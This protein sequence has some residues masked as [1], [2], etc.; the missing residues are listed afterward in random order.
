MRARL[1][2]LVLSIL[3]SA[4]LWSADVTP[5]VSEPGYAVTGRVDWSTATLQVEISHD[6][7]PSTASL[8][9]AKGDA[10]TDI[11]GRLPEFFSRAISTVTVDSSRSY[12]A[13]LQSDPALYAQVNDLA[14]AARRTELFLSTDFTR[15]V[16]RYAVPLF[17][18]TGI[19]APLFPGQASPIRAV[20][21]DVVTR[22]YTGLLVFAQGALPEA[23][24]TRTARARPALFP[25]IWDEQ[26][27]LVLDRRMCSPASLARWGM[28]G[29]AKGLD[30]A[31]AE[32]RVGALP[33]R[34]SAR[35]VFGDTPTDIVI[36]TEGARQLLALP[37]NIALLREGRIVIVY[38]RLD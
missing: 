37:E 12:G 5:L 4:P 38:D 9:R 36:S 30:D 15:L 35:A 2:P 8:V 3:A 6:L 27:N 32:L 13:I 14:L 7:D 22:R 10:E 31:A 25:R 18:D 26:M 28:V 33:L 21:G 24:T 23:G 11:D 17:G 1:L 20:L 29:Y 16:A 34:L 19:A